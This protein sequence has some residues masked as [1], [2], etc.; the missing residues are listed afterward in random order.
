MFLKRATLA[1]V[2]TLFVFAGFAVA[3]ASAA[4]VWLIE[5]KQLDEG[6]T[7]PLAEGAKVTKAFVLKV[8]AL[9]LEVE[10]KTLK[11]K[12][13]KLVGS[14]NAA[15]KDE[16]E[17]LKFGECKILGALGAKCEIEGSAIT[18]NALK[19]EL[20][21]GI[22][23]KLTAKEGETLATVAISNKG[24][25]KC[26]ATVSGKFHITGTAGAAIPEAS[27]ELVE[28]K[29]ELTNKS[30]SKVLFAEKEA[31]LTG[32][33]EDEL[34]TGK[35]W[36]VL[37]L[38]N[39]ARPERVDFEDN[40]A[41]LIDHTADTLHGE[42]EAA[43]SINE[44]G[45]NNT[46][47]WESTE[48][49]KVNKNWPVVYVKGENAKLAEARFAV[50]K[51]TREYLETKVEGLIEIT[52]ETAVGGTS[53][54]FSKQIKVAEIK[55]QLE[56]FGYIYIE[57]IG[58]SAALPS[59]VLKSFATITW[60]WLLKEIGRATEIEQELGKSTHNFYLL[61][62]KPLAGTTLYF[63]LL[64]LDTI[65]IS[66]QE[67]PLNSEKVIKGVWEGFKNKTKE[68]G[69]TT[70]ECSTVHIRT[71]NTSTGEVLRAETSVL[72]Y[73]E[74]ITPG[75][76]LNEYR[77]LGAAVCG[78]RFRVRQLLATLAGECGA[79][80]RAFKNAL[81]TEGIESTQL[82]IYVKYGEGVCLALYECR[83]LVK[84]W[85]FVEKGS[86][87]EASFPWKESEV[88][89]EN[90]LTGQGV[91]N[92]R[93]FFINHQ[94]IEV[95]N[96]LYDPSYGSE[97]VGDGKEGETAANLEKYQEQ[98]ITGFCREYMAGKFN[99]APAEAGSLRLASTVETVG[100][101]E[102]E[103]VVEEE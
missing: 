33:A 79:W 81:A 62:A 52:G 29:F 31:E 49:G 85:H 9:E 63:T 57:K 5:G 74:P 59:K 20:E 37:V 46:V 69:C 55:T 70:L 103:E 72:W 38:P 95:G 53:M 40:Q 64:D 60:K 44:V 97:P 24:T 91:E 1:G 10:C 56:L 27:S 71:Y 51:A 4:P 36:S 88:E 75:L 100:E 84:L 19:S 7:A 82:R 47:E 25:E 54:K 16:A 30:G 102:G 76:R 92:P 17:S 42:S 50:E 66:K 86:S 73:Y 89:D 77:A 32:I 98:S 87:G 14:A 65:E 3:S 80:A 101:A 21:E 83:M 15:G 13:A 26:P 96:D 43:L 90:G 78:G 67:E 48:R 39:A 28:H 45:G 11:A 2:L 6:E 94:I 41:V 23:D 8:A 99:C 12:G 93:S 68:G 22:K 34:T 58:S 18:T 61:Y 35:K